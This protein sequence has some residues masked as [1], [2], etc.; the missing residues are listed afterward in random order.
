MKRIIQ[1]VIAF[2]LLGIGYSTSADT[3]VFGNHPCD[4]AAGFE[5]VLYNDLA[6][7]GG[8]VEF[9]PGQNI[10][11]ASVTLWLNGYTGADG[12]LISAGIYENDESQSFNPG[13]AASFPGQEILTFTSPGANDGSLAAFTF[14]NPVGNPVNDPSDS[15]ML[16]AN[17]SYWLVVTASGLPGN[18]THVAT[19]AGGGTPLGTAT[20][21]C[22]DTYDVYRSAYDTS[23]ALP[24]FTLNAVPEPD[25]KGF[26]GL[27]LLLSA[28]GALRKKLVRKALLRSQY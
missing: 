23:S 12:Q 10:D 3:P 20:Y 21:N 2:F 17:T 15:A 28:S 25:F 26:M 24:A 16:S 22:S 13:N 9:T 19:W 18:Y 7:L 1:T 8:A 4:N 27:F 11:L 5:I 6:I 14:S